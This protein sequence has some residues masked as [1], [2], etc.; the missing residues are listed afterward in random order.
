MLN[1]NKRVFC[2]KPLAKNT[3]DIKEFIKIS[4]KKEKVMQTD[5]TFL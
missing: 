5:F 2:E 3:K 4:K 1:N